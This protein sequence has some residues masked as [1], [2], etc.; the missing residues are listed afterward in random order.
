MAESIS[1][2][3]TTRDM[4]PAVEQ[5][6][7]ISN[8]LQE[9]FVK[10]AP[11]EHDTDILEIDDVAGSNTVAAYT[12]RS[13]DA[14]N[15][16]HPGFNS[17]IHFLPYTKQRMT[18]T[19]KDLTERNPSETVYGGS[20]PGQRRDKKMGKFLSI[21]TDRL[22]RREEL[23]LAQ[24]FTTGTA[25]IDAPGGAYT[26]T[27]G[28]DGSNTVTLSGTD[29]WGESAEDMQGDFE[30]AA[31]QM[32]TPGIDGGY[33]TDVIMGLAAG[34]KWM[35]NETMRADLD[36]RRVINGEV[37]PRLVKD[38]FASYLGYY[39]GANVQCDV[40]TY[41]NQYVNTSGSAAYF[42]DTNDVWFIN[43]SVRAEK[44][45]SMISNLKSGNFMGARFPNY[46]IKDDGSAAIL[47]VE[48]GPLVAVFE[49]NKTYC[50]S[51]YG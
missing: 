47:Q 36:N 24:A 30:T 21:M 17:K 25:V 42:L 37:N 43:G 12:P 20:T 22:D 51:T 11:E 26:I 18:L 2:Q 14:D 10:G 29:R 15:L 9:S 44:H 35:K 40:W 23:Q 8:F 6:R 13:G 27:Y 33:Y 48:S 4:L 45:Y 19:A 39:N 34:R 16:S 46:W 50:L 1:T 28:R 31:D 41:F 38:K 5:S 3:Y 7:P 49:P 32:L